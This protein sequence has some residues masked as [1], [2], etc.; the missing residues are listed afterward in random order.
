MGYLAE[1]EKEKLDDFIEMFENGEEISEEFRLE[2]KAIV[3]KFWDNINFTLKDLLDFFVACDFATGAPLD[4]VR[5][6]FSKVNIIITKKDIKRGRNQVLERVL[7]KYHKPQVR[8]ILLDFFRFQ[9]SDSIYALA[10]NYSNEKLEDE[11]DNY[12]YHRVLWVAYTLL[13][14]NEEILNTLIEQYPEDY[15]HALIYYYR[16]YEKMNFHEVMNEPEKLVKNA[17]PDHQEVLKENKRIKSKMNKEA[18]EKQSLRK[19]VYELQQQKKQMQGEIH[20]L[21]DDS[22]KEIEGLKIQLE[23]QQAEFQLE[24]EMLSELIQSLTDKHNDLQEQ[25]NKYRS[26][27]KTVSLEGKVVCLVGGNRERHYREVVENYG[28]IFNF[29]PEDDFNKIRGAV[30]KSDV[31]FFLKEVAGHDHFRETYSAAKDNLVPFRF[32]NTKGISTFETELVH[33]MNALDLEKSQIS[34]YV[35]KG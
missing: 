16:F 21:Y 23:Q 9:H 28:G 5:K 34:S 31:V 2:A 27:Q 7:R 30:N 3:N 26:N 4:L 35:R 20:E 22:L 11:I 15:I 25:L 19:E 17:V 10:R 18:K 33:F 12:G 8:E 32:L 13:D 29:V 1:N 6:F 24:R 14:E